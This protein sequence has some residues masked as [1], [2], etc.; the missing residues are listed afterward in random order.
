MVKPTRR[1]EDG[2]DVNLP[3]QVKTGA[4][5]EHIGAA[6][7]CKSGD[8]VRVLVYPEDLAK[9]HF[10]RLLETGEVYLVPNHKSDPVLE[11]GTKECL[12]QP[13]CAAAREPQIAST[14]RG[15]G[16]GLFRQLADPVL[17]VEGFVNPGT[18]EFNTQIVEMTL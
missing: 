3:I 16:V 14:D 2:H 8:R 1:V 15:E 18:V 12:V 10:L 13:D 4:T 6:G 17:D 11:S 9:G 5:G 7:H